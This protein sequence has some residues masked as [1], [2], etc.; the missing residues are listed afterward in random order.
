[1]ILLTR[2]RPSLALLLPIV[3]IYAFTIRRGSLHDHAARGRSAVRLC[4]GA[5]TVVQNIFKSSSIIGFSWRNTLRSKV[6]TSVDAA[7]KSAYLSPR[8]HLSYSQCLDDTFI[9]LL[10]GSSD[11]AAISVVGLLVPLAGATETSVRS[12][13]V[14]SLVKVLGTFGAGGRD[15]AV[16]DTWSTLKAFLTLLSGMDIGPPA[17]QGAGSGAGSED[18][19]GSGAGVAGKKKDEEPWFPL[20]LSAC[21]LYPAVYR[22]LPQGEGAMRDEKKVMLEN[23]AVLCDDEM[24]MVR[25]N[26]AAALGGLSSAVPVDVFRDHLLPI[27]KLVSED[28]S[29]VVRETG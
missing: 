26:A 24:P 15:F 22:C 18:G 6:Y 21:E 4:N 5:F 25:A 13:A 23:F 16:S 14:K 28:R 19:D 7:S 12:R 2:S 27:F 10:G 1:M 9:P 3:Q 17:G 20:K 29:D 8:I 11:K